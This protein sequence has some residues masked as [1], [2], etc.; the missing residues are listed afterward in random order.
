MSSGSTPSVLARARGQWSEDCFSPT[1]VFVI[2]S[3][4]IQSHILCKTFV[5]HLLRSQ[6]GCF[7]TSSHDAGRISGLRL[8]CNLAVSFQYTSVDSSKA[9]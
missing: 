3:V 1:L 6:A 2:L 7:I 9:S 4:T 8:Y 5:I